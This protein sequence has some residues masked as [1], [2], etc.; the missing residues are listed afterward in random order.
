MTELIEVM[1]HCDLQV[2]MLEAE[3]HTLMLRLSDIDP[4]ALTRMEILFFRF[5]KEYLSHLDTLKH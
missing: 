2:E 4:N 1:D 3:I 5:K